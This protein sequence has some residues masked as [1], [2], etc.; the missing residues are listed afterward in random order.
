MRTIGFLIVSLIWWVPELCLAQQTPAR[1]AV[2]RGMFLVEETGFDSADQAET[3]RRH[4]SDGIRLDA[5]Y[6]VVELKPDSGLPRPCG[7]QACLAQL[8]KLAQA[9]GAVQVDVVRK[10]DGAYAVTVRT[11]HAPPR[12]EEVDKGLAV[13]FEVARR[14]A[15]GASRRIGEAA[16]EP[17][18]AAP[19]DPGEIAQPES[20][21]KHEEVT[22]EEPLP[23]GPGS[24][25]HKGW[26]WA[27]LG[28]TGAVVLSWGIVE[29]VAWGRIQSVEEQESRTRA[30]VDDL[31]GIQTGA[32]A[33]LVSGAAL[34]V[35]TVV[36]AL[37]TDFET[38]KEPAAVV[39]PVITDS[40]WGLGLGGRF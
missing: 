8:S 34:A 18:E 1:I 3:V 15:G 28:L 10:K 13:V 33:L 16:P 2:S 35:T 20:G 36:L 23:Q 22:T 32:R 27:S 9:Q 37:V 24:G 38:D 19:L 26:F 11:S 40:A 21:E 17:P 6:Q 29:A 14:L 7:D 39:A 5:G 30:D 4:A 12:I 31:R 25:L